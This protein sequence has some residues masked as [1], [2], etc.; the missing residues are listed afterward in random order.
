[1]NDINPLLVI[2]VLWGV[3][4]WHELGHM[5]AARWVGVPVL[6]LSIGLGPILWQRTMH[7]APDLALRAL[8]LGM[9]VTIPNRRTSNGDSLRPHAHDLWIAAGGPCANFALTLLLF[10][11]A[12]WV[13]MPHSWAYG[14]VGVG[15]F[16]SAI[17]LFNLLPIPG[18]DG[19]HL[20]MAGAARLGWEMKRS[21]ETRLHRT[22]IRLVLLA[23]L[24][25]LF[26]TLWSAF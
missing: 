3:I 12:R 4:L 2:A 13:P 9:S 17:A 8:P 26:N 16:S 6:R 22:G 14:V 1:M 15:I 11:I 19:G 7:D 23:S 20:F 5:V 24:L 21:H 10:A 18:L 25:P